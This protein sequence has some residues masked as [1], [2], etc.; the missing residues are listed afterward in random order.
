MQI[1]ESICYLQTLFA[2]ARKVVPFSQIV[3]VFVEI[4]LFWP[5]SVFGSSRTNTQYAQATTIDLLWNNT[6][7]Q[8]SVQCITQCRTIQQYSTSS[9]YTIIL[10]SE[11][12]PNYRKSLY[13][14]LPNECSIQCITQ[15]TTITRLWNNTVQQIFRLVKCAQ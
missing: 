3:S 2:S 6:V 1:F 4:S 14:R 13:R 9:A 15:V 10:K 5:G 12:S 7:Q 8:T 11:I